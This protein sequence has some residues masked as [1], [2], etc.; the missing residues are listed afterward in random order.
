M[1]KNCAIKTTMA[2][3]AT[4]FLLTASFSSANA[5]WGGGYG[6]TPSTTPASPPA[7]TGGYGG[8]QTRPT[9]DTYGGGNQ[10][11]TNYPSRPCRSCGTTQTYPDRP[12]HGT[13]YLPNRGPVY[14]PG[15]VYVPTNTGPIYRPGPVYVPANTGPIYRPGPVYV[16][17]NNGP[18]YRPGPVYVPQRDTNN[19]GV[20]GGSQRPTG[21]NGG[22]QP[23]KTSSNWD[24]SG[25]Y[26]GR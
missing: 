21:G 2:A 11:T 25:G 19:G 24:T 22:W 1:S 13:V 9:T 8:G 10:Q 14:R 5:A 3:V 6:G 7:Q 16:P 18:I 23:S 15:P 12:N 20:Y 4:A 26:G 17:A